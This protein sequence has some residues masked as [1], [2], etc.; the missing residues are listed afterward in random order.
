MYAYEASSDLAK[1]KKG[2]YSTYQGSASGRG[3]LPQDTIDLLE[4]ERGLP[5]DVPRTS[6]MDWSGRARQDR[7][8]R[9]AKQQRPRHRAHR[10]HLEHHGLQPL[11][12]APVHQPLREEQSLSGDFMVLNE[13]LGPRP[14]GPRPLDPPKCSTNSNTT[15]GELGSKS[16]R[17]L[18]GPQAQIRA[19]PS[20]SSGPWLIDAAAR[21]QKWIDQSQSVNLFFGQADLRWPSAFKDVPRRLAPRPQDHLLPPHPQRLQHRKSH[22]RASRKETWHRHHPR[23]QRRRNRQIHRRRKSPAPSKRCRNGTECE[24]CQ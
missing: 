21:R 8:P 1:P 7:P 19:P 13:F 11:H 4:T 2:T 10:H 12:R 5:I 15:D 3:L 17:S 14:Q 9:H 18:S 22:Q 16:T 23:G 6:K 24:V 20:P